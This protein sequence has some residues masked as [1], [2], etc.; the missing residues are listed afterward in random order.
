MYIC[1]YT[2]VC[3]VS[4][5]VLAPEITKLDQVSSLGTATSCPSADRLNVVHEV[6][7][8][9]LLTCNLR[10]VHV[11]QQPGRHNVSSTIGQ[12]DYLH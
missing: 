10:V 3:C 6:P 1:I 2:L 8:G 12:L 4:Y 9:R 7:R 11:V 5:T